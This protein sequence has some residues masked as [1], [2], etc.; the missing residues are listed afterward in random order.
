[1]RG[2]MREAGVDLMI[3]SAARVATWMAV[4][5]WIFLRGTCL[6]YIVSGWC[7]DGIRNNM[8]RSINCIPLSVLTP[9][10]MRTP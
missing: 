9:M 2:N 6:K 7:L 3:H 5:R 8:H 10:Y 1:M 4:N